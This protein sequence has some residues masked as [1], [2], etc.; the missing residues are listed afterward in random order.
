MTALGAD[1][2]Q[3]D[4]LI[5][6]TS[7]LGVSPPPTPRLIEIPFI[8]VF[9]PLIRCR[10]GYVD[11]TIAPML[12]LF[13]SVQF[14][15]LRFSVEI[16]GKSGKLEF[17]AQTSTDLPLTDEEWL[18]ATVYQRFA[19]NEHGD[20]FGDFVFPAEHPF[21]T[22]LKAVALGNAPPQL[23]FRFLGST[24]DSCRVRGKLVIRGGGHGIIPPVKLTKYTDSKAD[25]VLSTR[26]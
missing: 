1:A 2:G 3:V 21:G 7:A 5:S 24:G 8:H 10:L 6:G 12:R 22:E 19:G 16:S 26:N 23:F 4:A 14:V 13:E 17:A 20:T 9:Q 15:D 11:S 25:S 18:G